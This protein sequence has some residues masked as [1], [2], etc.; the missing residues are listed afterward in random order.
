MKS[1][2]LIVP[3]RGRP[4]NIKELIKA[5]V[6]TE[7]K[8]TDLILSLDLDDPELVKYQELASQIAHI[9]VAPRQG[10][11]SV[12]PANFAARHLKKDYEYFIMMGDD[13]RPRTKG[14][15]K[16]FIEALA[17]LGTG[18]VYG[19]DLHRGKDLPTGGAAMTGNIVRALDGVAPPNIKHLYVDNFY[20]KLGQDLDAITYLPEVIIEH[21]HPV[22]GTALVDQGYL[23]VNSQEMYDH[24]SMALNNYIN[25]QD[26]QDLLTKLR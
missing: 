14:W 20:L 13:S 22:F 21:L 16:Q 10:V 4:D 24:D 18:L 9:L 25:S 3:T 6:D 2:A 5:L 15:D 8:D 11:G 17:Q 19:N 23:D 26:Y 1:L 12:I 7:T